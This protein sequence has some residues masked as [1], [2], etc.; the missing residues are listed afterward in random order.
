MQKKTRRKTRVKV[1]TP[2]R[3]FTMFILKVAGC[4]HQPTLIFLR[5]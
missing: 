5:N 4:A 3:N 2:I 1:L